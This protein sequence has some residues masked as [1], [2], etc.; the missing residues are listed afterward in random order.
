MKLCQGKV[1]IQVLFNLKDLEKNKI[2]IKLM[3]LKKVNKILKILR[4]NFQAYKISQ[5]QF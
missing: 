3:K 4:R 1:K 2:K 5:V